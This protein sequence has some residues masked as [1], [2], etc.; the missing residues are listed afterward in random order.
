PRWSQLLWR[1]LE[2]HS[3]RA[4]GLLIVC[5]ASRPLANTGNTDMILPDPPSA[6]TYLPTQLSD[7]LLYFG[8]FVSPD[9]AQFAPA[10]HLIRRYCRHR[11]KQSSTGVAGAQEDDPTPASAH[12]VFPAFTFRAFEQFYTSR[13]AAAVVTSGGGD[14]LVVPP[15][16]AAEQQRG[17][18]AQLW[19]PRPVQ[20]IANFGCYKLGLELS[21]FALVVCACLRV[22]ALSCLYLGLLLVFGFLSRPATGRFWPLLHL[23]LGLASCLACGLPPFLCLR[24]PWFTPANCGLFTDNL[25]QWLFLPAYNVPPRAEKLIAGLFRL[26]SRH[27]PKSRIS[28]GNRRQVA[29]LAASL[30]DTCMGSNNP[31]QQRNCLASYSRLVFCWL[32]WACSLLLLVLGFL[33]FNAYFSFLYILVAFYLLC[34][35]HRFL[36]AETAPPNPSMESGAVA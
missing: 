29:E 6:A 35:G 33:S 3:H 11:R 15:A 34:N 23:L 10:Q 9:P 4:I 5:M 7:N 18:P 19:P 1:L 2:L 14:C 16:Q 25:R 27:L 31:H 22:D 32:F 13:M 26:G 8:L 36:L 20:F 30:G 12:L 24:Y 28:A 21:Y 17:L